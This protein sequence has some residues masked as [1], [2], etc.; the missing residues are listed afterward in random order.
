M[1]RIAGIIL[2]AFALVISFGNAFALHRWL[3]LPMAALLLGAA[4]FVLWLPFCPKSSV[5]AG[6]FGS[7][8]LFLIGFIGSLGL[9]VI[10]DGASRTKNLTHAFA[11]TTVILVYGLFLKLLFAVDGA[12][13][14][15]RQRIR[16]AIALSTFLVSCF[17]IVE[18]FDTNWLHVGVS[19]LIPFVLDDGP[20][21]PQFLVFTR[22]RGFEAESALLA[23]YL[24]IFLPMSYVWVRTRIGRLTAWSLLVC[25]GGALLVTFST[26]GFSALLLGLCAAI[27]LYLADHRLAALPMR[28]VMMAFAV[29]L[30][31][32]LGTITAPAQ[33]RSAVWNKITFGAG[34]SPSTRLARWREA[35]TVVQDRPIL[36]TGIGST[37]QET[38][39]GV[40][41]FYLTILKEGG[42]PALLLISAYLAAILTMVVQL[43]SYSPFKYAYAIALVAAVVHY[44]VISDIWFPWIW[45]L[46]ILI[47]DERVAPTDGRAPVSG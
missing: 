34:P 12:G 24:T 15:Y 6:Y 8:D 1:G 25:G 41:S 14:T 13:I 4:V 39:T 17:A 11:Y 43:P 40:I 29:A 16:G 21:N 35:I 18:F 3:P 44:A 7:V 20:Y 42:I 46:A 28:T 45:L 30:L 36:G 23:L 31:A 2:T 10:F 9:G 33:A 26:A 38:G 47:V 5:R 37:S 19:K 32:I 27:V 22:A